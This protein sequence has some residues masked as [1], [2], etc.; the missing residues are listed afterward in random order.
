MDPQLATSSPNPPPP[1]DPY[2]AYGGKVASTAPANSADPYAAYGGKVAGGPAPAAAQPAAPEGWTKVASA[3]NDNAMAPWIDTGKGLVKGGMHTVAGLLNMFAS[4]RQANA[5]QQQQQNVQGGLETPEQAAAAPK[6][7]IA[8]HV[9]DGADWLNAHAQDHGIWQHI[10]DFGESALELMT[11]EALAGLVGDTSGVAKIA[12]AG[13]AATQVSAKA[14]QLADANKVASMLD[15]FPRIKALMMIGAKAA[16][17]GGAEVGAQTLVKTGGDTDAAL[18]TGAEGAAAGGIGAPLLTAA[19]KGAEALASKLRTPEP[20]ASA[21]LGAK[22]DELLNSVGPSSNKEAT[23]AAVGKT[24]DKLKSAAA[25]DASAAYNPLKAPL[26]LPEDATREQIMEA[27]KKAAQPTQSAILGADGKP[28]MTPGDGGKALDDLREADQKYVASKATTDRALV[29]RIANTNR[30]ELVHDYIA[31]A[32]LDDMRT[33]LPK[34]D[35]PTRNAVARNVMEDVIA[36]GGEPEDYNA[37]YALKALGKLDKDGP[38]SGLLFGDDKAGA[39]KSTLQKIAAATKTDAERAVF[40]AAVKH[41]GNFVGG[42][43]GGE[44]GYEAGGWKGAAIGSAAGAVGGRAVVSA[45]LRNPKIANNLLFAI[46]SGA[47][48]ERYGPMIGAMIQE[49]NAQDAP[50]E[51]QK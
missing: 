44:A 42:A 48:P 16:A 3:I 19:G 39:L 20:S 7:V 29:Q 36:K 22:F 33:L 41:V 9:K 12:K 35:E 37:S 6:D 47:R 21:D 26:G 51:T 50:T 30:P 10:G 5:D 28:T 25:A 24:V 13:E 45:I 18:A 15:K 43:L 17:K 46:Q 31:K 49:A 40:G 27:A 11:P 8:G 4:G 1:P 23:G 14:A 38:K 32:S 34:L 2:A